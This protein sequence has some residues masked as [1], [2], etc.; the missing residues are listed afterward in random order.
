MKFFDRYLKGIDNGWEQTPPVRYSVLDPGGT[1]ETSIESPVFPPE[2]TEYVKYYLKGEDSSLAV[3]PCSEEKLAY[4]GAD[5]D[6][7]LEFRITFDKDTTIIGY[8]K[9]KLYMEAEGCHDMD[10]FVEVS[11]ENADG[12]LVPW[13]CTPHNRYQEEVLGFE[14]RLRASMRALDRELSTDIIPVHSFEKPDYLNDNELAELDIPIR[15]FGIRWR[16][17][18]TLVFRIGNEY[19][20]SLKNRRSLGKANEGGRHIV[21]C[22]G[23]KA[24][25]IQLPVMKN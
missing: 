22:G 10:V 23:S 4:D 1:D 12:N 6:A 21:W 16:A 14:G 9:A 11:K 8:P 5:Q 24:S 2:N 20:A 25:Y 3:V 18:E 13:D 15:P 17:G 7:A 19:R